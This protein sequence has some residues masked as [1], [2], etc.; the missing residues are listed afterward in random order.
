ML[1]SDERFTFTAEHAAQIAALDC[2]HLHRPDHLWLLAETGDE[3]LDYRDGVKRYAGA[4]QTVLTGG[5]H[6]FTRWEDYLDDI[7]R[8]AG[9]IG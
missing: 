4:R 8:F 1:Y 3:V 7:L 5:D 6:G 2:P 9:L